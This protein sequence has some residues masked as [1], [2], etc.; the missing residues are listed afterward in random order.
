MNSDGSMADADGSVKSGG[1]VTDAGGSSVPDVGGG[2]VTDTDG[3]VRV[4]SSVIGTS[5]GA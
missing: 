5:F 1:S 3:C 2:P 4:D